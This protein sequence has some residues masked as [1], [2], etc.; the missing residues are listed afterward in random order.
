[1]VPKPSEQGEQGTASLGQP[2]PG[3]SGAG[4]EAPAGGAQPLLTLR[5]VTKRYPG[6]VASSS[7]D[8]DIH[9]G[10]VHA[11]VGEN[12]AGKSTL[13][14]ILAGVVKPD[15]GEIRMDGE[16]VSFRG[17]S[18]ARGRGISLVPQELS[19]APHLSVAENVFLGHL[20][21]RMGLVDKSAMRRETKQLFERLGVSVDPDSRLGDHPPAVQQMAMIAH[22]IA[23]KGR[24]FILDEP[25]AALTDPEI[26]RLFV[27]L[28]ELRAGGA[29][30]IYVSHRLKELGEIGDEITVLRDG[31]IVDRKPAQGTS[32]NELVRAMVGRS[33]ERFFDKHSRK[34]DTSKPALTVSALSRRD[35]FEDVG[36]TLYPGEVVG[37]AGLMGAGRTEVARALFG[38]DRATGGEIRVDDRPVRVRSPRDAIEAGIILVPEER[39][40]QGLVVDMSI[41]DNVVMP[42]LRS[43]SRG[44]FFRERRLREYAR[45]ASERMQVKAS[46][47]QTPVRH[48][49]GGNQQKVVLGRWL[50]QQP[51]VYLLDEPTRGIDVD[52]K[53][54]IY[55]EIGRLADGGAAVL[56]ISS[57]LPELIATCD[58][59]LVMRAGRMVG[60]VAG[61]SATEHEIL[62]L[63]MGTEVA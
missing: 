43:L 20:P 47:V 62:E 51:R 30:I 21:R 44:W 61:A 54:E 41:S 25:T 19:M 57:E 9:A 7:I 10:R 5:G 34:A 11:L 42:H 50:T 17:P 13:I 23:M 18:D 8:L 2:S 52:V 49:S 16:P 3:A 29:G 45:Q 59:I 39:K 12:G 38:V 14:K 32:E 26:E 55:R 63:A 31:Q 28:R 37:L 15:E 40:S 24:I 46:G 60:E 33:V 6:V 35:V 1:V 53:S 48:L 4:G 56:L 22:G 27:V 58:R 36:F